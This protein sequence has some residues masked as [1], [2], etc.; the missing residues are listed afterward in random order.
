MN[1]GNSGVNF[2]SKDIGLKRIRAKEQ[3]LALRRDVWVRVLPLTAST[4]HFPYF[5]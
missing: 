3:L 4:D 5:E 1:A 2:Q